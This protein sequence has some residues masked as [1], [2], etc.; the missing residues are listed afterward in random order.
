MDNYAKNQIEDV[1][2]DNDD[3]EFLRLQIRGDGSA[4]KYL[5]I[6]PEQAQKIADI[7]AE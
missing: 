7:M 2:K 3:C 1:I 5:N 4:T 6:S